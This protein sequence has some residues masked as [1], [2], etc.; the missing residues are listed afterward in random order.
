MSVVGSVGLAGSARVVPGA[1]VVSMLTLVTGAFHSLGVAPL[2][3]GAA[4]CNHW[5]SLCCLPITR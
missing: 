5:V 3:D 1:P 4:C 2:A